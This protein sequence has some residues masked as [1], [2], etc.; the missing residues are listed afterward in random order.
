MSDP[1]QS[2]FCNVINTLVM[3]K[4]WWVMQILQNPCCQNSC[5]LVS[6]A[7]L[8]TRMLKAW[9]M[10]GVPYEQ[11]LNSNI[12]VTLN[13][14][15]GSKCQHLCSWKWQSSFVH[16]MSAKYSSW[17][18]LSLAVNH[19]LR[20]KWCSRKKGQFSSIMQMLPLCISWAAEVLYANAPCVDE[21]TCIRSCTANTINDL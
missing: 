18:N 14:A 9:K 5:F 8:L 6:H 19:S 10:S 16:L 3:G 21:K 12:L 11:F 20:W 7:N 4:L 17:I 1:Y 13:F 2:W 15:V